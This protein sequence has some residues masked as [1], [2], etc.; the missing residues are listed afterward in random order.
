MPAESSTHEVVRLA[1]GVFSIRSVTSGETFHP[2]AGPIAEAETLYVRQLRLRERLAHHQQTDCGSS[3]EFVIW[4]IGL[5]GGGNAFTALRQLSDV[6]GHLRIVSFDRTLDALRLALEH[7]NELQY[8][9]GFEKTI[10][11][12]LDDTE[13]DFTHGRLRV[14]WEIR[15]GDFPEALMSTAAGSFALPS[16]HAIF[17]DAFSPARNPEMW[18]LSLFE[19]LF[20]C[21]DPDQPCSL[22]TF[23]RSTAAR[24]AMLLAGFFV[25]AGEP[26]AG[27]EETTVAANSLELIRSPLDR[28]WL[29]RAR[30]SRNAEPLE[31]NKY[32]RASLSPET[33]ERLSCHPQFQ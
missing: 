24:V 31:G 12:L 5:G 9:V 7:A 17:F 10:Q 26:V 22:A 6:T 1:N 21:L 15:L 4:D 30:I 3:G 19:N 25:G 14:N 32:R 18:T 8:P 28:R 23:S 2:V 20:R 33:W 27:K 16:P 11:R 13:S 29:E